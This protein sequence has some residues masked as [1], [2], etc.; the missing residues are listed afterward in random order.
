MTRSISV[1]R[2]KPGLVDLLVRRRTGKTGFRFSA[3]ANFDAAFTNFAVVPNH[4]IKSPSVPDVHAAGVGSQF[5]DQTRFV[6]D[7][8]DYTATAAAL[9]D[10]NPFFLRIEPRNPDGTFG[11]PEAMHLIMPPPVEP[12][13]AISLRGTIPSG[14]T[15]ANS[16]EIQLPGQCNDFDIL[17]DG[18]T[19][20]F[21]AFH[22]TGGEY[23]ID[24]V[25]TSFRA[26]EQFT[27]SI[28]QIFLRG[29]GGTTTASMVF[30]LRNNGLV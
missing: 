15:L 5:R 9:V 18:A 25:S 3:S 6:F 17:N 20:M 12:N 11:S 29:S 7:P 21:A 19:I 14:A 30:T 26:F 24:P 22:P 1:Y 27:T 23:Q 8:A 2:R 13:R 16:L 10:T 4:G 28:S